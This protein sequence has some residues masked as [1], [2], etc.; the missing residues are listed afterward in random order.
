MLTQP[1]PPVQA[2]DY[3]AYY[4]DG[5]REPFDE[6]T[7]LRRDRLIFFA[8]AEC[9]EGQG[10]FAD[11]IM[12]EVWAICEA[13]TWVIPAH[14][15]KY[16]HQ[17]P[18]PQTPIVDLISAITS[19]TLAEVDYLLGD[20]LHPAVRMRIRHEID[21]RSTEAFLARD[22]YA[23]LGNI[24]PGKKLGPNWTPVCAGGTACAA[25]YLEPDVDRLAAVLAKTFTALRYYLSTFGSD[26][27]C[28]EGI[29]YW[30]KGFFF[31][32]ALAHLLN[33][34]TQGQIDLLN[35]PHVRRIA[36]FPPQVELSPGVF[37]AFSD[38]GVDRRPQYALLHFLA[39]Y[40]G[41]PALAALDHNGSE[42]RRLTNRGP[43]EKIRDL[44]WYPETFQP[45]TVPQP[46]A[47]Y[48]PDIQWLIARAKPMDPSG[49]VL[50][51]KGG[52]NAEPHNHNDVGS[53]IVHWRGESLIAELGA[54]R[55]T[56]DYFK[57]ELRTTFLSQSSRGH[58][59]PVVNGYEQGLGA[60]FRAST[61]QYI[62]EPDA[63]R[64]RIDYASAYP[65]EADLAQ[66]ERRL[67]IIRSEPA[68]V[69]EVTDTAIFKSQPGAFESV[70]ISFADAALLEPGQALIGGAKGRLCVEYDA[71][72]VDARVERIENVDLRHGL[73]T[74]AR[75][76]FALRRNAKEAQITLRMTPLL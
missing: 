5:Q 56:R 30:E 41:M 54:G 16:A 35:D 62:M 74:V 31:Y 59:V 55:Y 46:P 64:L 60:A 33:E 51:A 57:P 2:T 58:S 1:T 61:V 40:Y 67:A 65:A 71:A 9:L 3:L 43:A 75:I 23:W 42:G 48:F 15:A 28:A 17:L 38:T 70:L 8:L 32:S 45:A 6:P 21:R 4:R 50:A 22:D 27:A 63:E 12:N 13:S 66:L 52:Y 53:F 26:G 7:D 18:D 10:R 73:M 72:Y 47:A 29:G 39:N 20:A 14:A 25:L 36:A 19:F 34:R 49:L 44:F 68:G 76:V 69:I 24:R 37:V 11:A